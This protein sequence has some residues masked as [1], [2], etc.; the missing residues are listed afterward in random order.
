MIDRE[1]ALAGAGQA[2]ASRREVKRVYERMLVGT[3]V[4]SRMFA[5]PAGRVHLLEKGDDGPPVVLLHGG[6]NGAG[7]LLPLLRELHGMRAIAPD[8]PGIGLTDPADLPV[9]SYRA[10]TV[11]W[12]DGLFDALG[13]DTVSLF[14]H[15]GG[16]V[17]AL[18]YA[19]DRPERVRRLMLV[20]VPTLPKTNCQLPL[21]LIS[22]P[23]VGSLLSRLSPPS[24]KSFL[25]I[26]E[27]VGEKESV[28]RLPDLVDL[29]VAIGRDPVAARATMTEFR[30]YISPF[31]L[32]SSSG[33]R[34]RGR[35][36]P[37]E[38]RTL[39]MPTLLLWGDRDPLGPPS[40]AHHVADLIPQGTL[41]MLPA[42]H[43]P[44][45]GLPARVAAAVADFIS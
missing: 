31:G 35:V 8:L 23:G 33:W 36:R 11:S 34:R 24:E 18:R 1:G 44:F 19:L 30:A 7:F 12:L 32:L 5:T 25:K 41:L 39:A 28:S 15:S 17:W 27:M 43:G 10:A 16:G 38:L 45:L 9:R 22:T 29:N 20:A 21:R 4:R 2:T 37:D 26:A 6:G 40:T 14:G 42:G 3:S 13:L